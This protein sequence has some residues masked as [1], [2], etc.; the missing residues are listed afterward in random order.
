ME[1]LGYELFFLP[2]Y[3]PNLNPIKQFWTTMKRWIN[4]NI[5]QCIG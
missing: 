4:C 5:T 2:P 1:S 3:S